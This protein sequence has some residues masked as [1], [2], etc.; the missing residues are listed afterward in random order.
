MESYVAISS[1]YKIKL[2]NDSEKKGYISEIK[3]EKKIKQVVVNKKKDLSGCY[4]IETNRKNIEA[5]EIWEFYMNLHE[6]DSAFS[7]IKSDQGTRPVYHQL[8]ITITPPNK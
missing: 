7:V 4:E 3:L 2:A 6:V 5:Q 1:L 8:D